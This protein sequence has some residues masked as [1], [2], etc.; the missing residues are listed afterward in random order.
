MNS[1][2]IQKG[3]KSKKK[4]EKNFLE[5]T[6]GNLALYAADKSS[7]VAIKKAALESLQQIENEQNQPRSNYPS[8][9]IGVEAGK[10]AAF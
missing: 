10:Q 9:R 8:P 4:L 1:P 7:P 5:I 3:F 6:R 2:I